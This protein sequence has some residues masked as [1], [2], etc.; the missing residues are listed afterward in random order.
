MENLPLIEYEALENTPLHTYNGMLF[1]AY[2]DGGLYWISLTDS[3]SPVWHPIATHP[4]EAVAVCCFFDR[5]CFLFSRNELLIVDLSTVG[6][7]SVS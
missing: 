5:W 3:T 1:I 2:S 7:G 6:L 4:A